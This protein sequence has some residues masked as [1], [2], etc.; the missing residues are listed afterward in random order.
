M[1]NIKLIELA[2]NITN[3]TDLLGNLDSFI[4]DLSEEQVSLQGGMCV[5]SDGESSGGC[6]DVIIDFPQKFDLTKIIQ[7]RK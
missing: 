4:R 5:A 3:E 7:K 6:A 2:A 1:A